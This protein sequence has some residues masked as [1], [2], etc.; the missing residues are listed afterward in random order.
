VGNGRILGICGSPRADGNTSYAVK[1]ALEVAKAE[2]FEVEYVGL[3]GKRV[4]PCTGC[5]TCSGGKPCVFKDD[6]GPILESMLAC[7]GMVVGTPV[8]FG[9]LSGQ[10]KA[11][12][13][14]T[15]PLRADYGSPLPL[16]GK[17]GGAIACANSRNGGQETAIQNIHT[18]FLQMNMLAVSDGPDFCHAGGTVFGQRAAD[19]EW[20]LRT[21]ENLARNV[22]AAIRARRVL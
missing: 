4:H 1:R 12:M 10:L 9:M 11:M 21:V 14:R 8:Y 16:A 20:G 22:C 13:D 18:Y 17:V 3:A 19:D 7:D 15:V 5:W 6:M 2:G